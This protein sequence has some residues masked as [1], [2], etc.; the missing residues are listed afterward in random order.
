MTFKDLWYVYDVNGMALWQF[1]LIFDQFFLLLFLPVSSCFFLFHIGFFAPFFQFILQIKLHE[2]GTDCLGLVLNWNWRILQLYDEEILLDENVWRSDLSS[3]S[4]TPLPYHQGTW[5]AWN[6][7][8]WTLIHYQSLLTTNTKGS[9]VNQ[10]WTIPLNGIW[11]GT[12]KPLECLP[13]FT[14]T[15]PP[16]LCKNT[17]QLASKNLLYTFHC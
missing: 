13:I 14:S 15:C 16:K 6:S 8:T 2:F 5:L 4:N 1:W 12:T 3:L 11:L 17:I 10:L 7:P 9:K